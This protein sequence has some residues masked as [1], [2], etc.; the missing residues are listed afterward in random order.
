MSKTIVRED[1]Y[2]VVHLFLA[3]PEARNALSR[4]LI[5]ELRAE[6]ET[7]ADDRRVRA[8]ILGSRD[9][10]FC[11][12]ADLREMKELLAGNKEQGREDTQSLRYLLEELL[13]LP[14]VVIAAVNGAALGG[15]CGLVTACDLA[16]AAGDATLGYPETRIGIVPALVAVLL[17]RLCGERVTRD[18]L[19]TGRVLSADEAKEVGLV[20]EVVEPD[21][22][23]QRAEELARMVAANSP[24]AISGTKRLLRQLRGLGFREAMDLA[25]YTNTMAREGDDLREGLSAFFEKRDPEWSA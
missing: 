15:G 25:V 3:R 8:V 9:K 4:E 14:Q 7:V 22:L 20:N 2:P 6:L 19:L 12:G 10:V 11:A 23:L 13:E 16:V 21:K 5:Q 18:L 1:D 24:A 17:S